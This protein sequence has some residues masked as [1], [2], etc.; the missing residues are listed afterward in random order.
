MATLWR[1]HR[2]PSSHDFSRHGHLPNGSWRKVDWWRRQR[3]EDQVIWWHM[4]VLT[5]SCSYYCC[6]TPHTA[7]HITA[8]GLLTQLFILLLLDSSECWRLGEWAFMVHSCRI[9]VPL[10]PPAYTNSQTSSNPAA[11]SQSLN[12]WITYGHSLWLHNVDF[13]YLI[14][15]WQT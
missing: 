2:S 5:H 3:E 9:F 13:I 11:C 15:L 1:P 12:L 6:W 14:G 8:A 4:R 10:S 7:V